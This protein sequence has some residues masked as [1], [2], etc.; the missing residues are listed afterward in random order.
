MRISRF[1]VLLFHFS[2]LC[3]GCVRLFRVFNIFGYIFS[4]GCN[5]KAQTTLESED[6]LLFLLQENSL[7][8]PK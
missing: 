5:T 4:V 3:A 2:F 1:F 8:D 6:K 7:S